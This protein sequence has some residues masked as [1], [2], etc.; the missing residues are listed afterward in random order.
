M[1]YLMIC[2]IIMNAIMAVLL[3]YTLWLSIILPSIEAFSLCRWYGRV[4]KQHPGVRPKAS[5][6]NIWW[7]NFHFFGRSF[8]STGNIYGKW[9]G[10]GDWEVYL[11]D[12]YE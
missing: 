11:E 4:I 3:I 10:I 8:D 1:G 9:R 7:A 2:G 6:V 12:E 5:W